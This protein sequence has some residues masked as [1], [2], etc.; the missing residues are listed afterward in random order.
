MTRKNR[1]GIS[2]ARVLLDNANVPI[3]KVNLETL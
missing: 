2:I 1:D 3:G